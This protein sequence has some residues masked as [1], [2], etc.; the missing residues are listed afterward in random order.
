MRW[1]ERQRAM[2]REMGIVFAWRDAPAVAGLASGDD[3]GEATGAVGPG[4]ASGAPERTGAPVAAPV[5]VGASA[6]AP[7]RSSPAASLGAAPL[8]ALGEAEWLVVTDPF[9]AGDA[10]AADQE[11]LLD[12]MLA[13]IGVSRSAP[14][15]AGRAALVGLPD[16]V[17]GAGTAATA[18]L[19]AAI[20]AV[21]PGCIL[22]LGRGAA[23]A[24]LDTDEPLGALRGR[25]EERAGV[26]VIVTFAPAYLLRHPA[27][28]AK[29]WSDLC[30]AVRCL[31][32][33][34]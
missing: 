11:R 24:V 27:E 16:A 6:A 25:R 23:Q 8:A 4:P 31:E 34:A 20:A 7:A 19:D 15:R 2:L 1:T 32:E 18:W 14:T 9:L 17:G 26:A 30:L 10:S 5:R 22:A 29:A 12:N 28:K 33:A 13:A 21:R 3:A